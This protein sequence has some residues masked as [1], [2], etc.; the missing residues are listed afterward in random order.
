MILV[1]AVGRTK[2][3][4]LRYPRKGSSLE[5]IPIPMQFFFYVTRESRYLRVEVTANRNLFSF[6]LAMACKA[7]KMTR[8][9][10]IL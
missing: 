3:K 2:D 10:S 1:V 9:L 4:S 6:S 5:K 8:D 7:I